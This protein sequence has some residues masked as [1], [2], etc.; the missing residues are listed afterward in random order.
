MI[1]IAFFSD[2]PV[3]LSCAHLVAQALA[4]VDARV[5]LVDARDGAP[6]PSGDAYAVTSAPLHTV[7]DE[8]L[9]AR[10][11]VVVTVG[12]GGASAGRA[13][14]AARYDAARTGGTGPTPAWFLPLSDQSI[15][16]TKARLASAHGPRLPFGTR[17]LPVMLPRIGAGARSRLLA[18][19]PDDAVLA[20]GTL[21]AALVLAVGADPAAAGLDAAGLAVLMAGGDGPGRRLLA[22]HLVALADAYAR[23][24]G[25]GTDAAGPTDQA[26]AIERRRPH[27]GRV[28]GHRAP[29]RRDG[30]RRSA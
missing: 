10:F 18:G 25:R 16:M 8:A 21:L 20:S 24:S 3:G 9:R 13:L 2:D 15:F 5:A 11:D 12:E 28:D 1:S 30:L 14:R 6:P 29:R 27:D 23:L 17:A 22:G 4:H 19:R 26:R 7:G